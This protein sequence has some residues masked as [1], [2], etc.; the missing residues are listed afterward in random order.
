MSYFIF[1]GV[2][3]CG[4]QYEL[5]GEE[6][7]HILKSRRMRTGDYFLVQDEKGQRFEVLLKNLSRNS[8]AFVPGKN[9]AVPPPSPL[10][11]EILQA[12]P[13]DKA[14]DFILQKTTELGVHRLDFFG[15]VHSSKVFR[16]SQAESQIVRWKRIAL[17]ASKQCGRQFPPEIY[18]HS[19]LETALSTLPECPNSWVLSPGSADSV[20]WNN[21]TGGYRA[22]PK[23]YQRVL[24]GPEGG[25]H[26]EEIE[27]ALRSGMRPVDLGPRIL[28]TETAAVSAVAIL[29]FLW[30]DFSQNK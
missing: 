1:N 2:L 3:E 29:Q 19:N 27:F 28:R 16:T 18:W 9:V 14:L 26:P 8:L 15:G 23:E 30:G 11:L 12:L 24:I 13:K 20:S 5:K 6:A 17:E 22:K 25:F 7:Q 4:N 21:S 10:K